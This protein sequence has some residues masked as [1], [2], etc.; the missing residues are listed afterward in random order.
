MPEWD[1]HPAHT[2]TISTIAFH[3]AKH[4]VVFYI[5]YFNLYDTGIIWPFTLHEDTSA[6]CTNDSVA[7]L[8]WHVEKRRCLVNL[9]S[10][11]D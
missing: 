2:A 4:R 3:S 1:W 7:F 9:Y 6:V 5:T 8:Q 10:L 11:V